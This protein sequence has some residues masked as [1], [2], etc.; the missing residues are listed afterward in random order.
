MSQFNKIDDNFAVA[1]QLPAEAMEAA[2]KEGF[3]AVIC[4]RPDDEDAG[5]PTL[6][7]MSKAA[8]R[9]G[10][11]FHAVPYDMR[12]LDRGVIDAFEAAI[13]SAD[14]PVLAYCRSGTRSTIGWCV[15]QRRAGKSMDEVL[16]AARSAGY[17]L[18]AQAPMIE[19]LV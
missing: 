15:I 14:G 17:E 16:S 3:H 19:A 11:A 4:N 2:A 1:P 7:D 10:L 13:A 12:T 18:S 5:Q 9:A 6:D 8:T